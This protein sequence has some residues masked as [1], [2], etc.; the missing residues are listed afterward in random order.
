MENVTNLSVLNAVA[1]VEL[2]YKSKVKPSQRPLI[3]S[4]K[5]CYDILL[6][7]R[8]QNKIEF[9]NAT[10]CNRSITLCTIMGLEFIVLLLIVE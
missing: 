1:E 7:N 6:Q 8:D 9:V 5:E 4:S 3:K 10:P 2:V